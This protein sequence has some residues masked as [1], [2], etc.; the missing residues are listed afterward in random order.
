MPSGQMAEPPAHA[1]T[2]YSRADS[3]AHDEANPRGLSYGANQKVPGNQWLASAAATPDSGGELR[4]TPQPGSRGKHRP[5]PPRAGVGQTLTRA[6]PF[7][8]LAAR[9]ARPARVR[10]RNRKP[11]V[12]ARRRLFG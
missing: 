8:R 10:M 3:A 11:C 5:S 2:D 7:R 9:T 12:L 1:V 4:L 6:R